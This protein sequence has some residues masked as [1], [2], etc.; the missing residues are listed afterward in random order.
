M[1]S[2]KTKNYKKLLRKVAKCNSWSQRAPMAIFART[3]NNN[4][5]CFLKVTES[6]FIDISTG[7]YLAEGSAKLA[8]DTNQLCIKI[9]SS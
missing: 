4:Q 6:R 7:L 8:D 1:W 2:I 3:R 5:F 9:I